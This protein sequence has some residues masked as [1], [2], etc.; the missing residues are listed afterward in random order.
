LLF[1]EY[2]PTWRDAYDAAVTSGIESYEVEVETKDDF[3]LDAKIAG[4]FGR[5]GF[6]IGGKYES[7]IYHRLRAKIDFR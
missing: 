2:E 3:G 1:F 7:H 5:R 4:E 6:S